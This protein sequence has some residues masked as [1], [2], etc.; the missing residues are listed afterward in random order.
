MP[1]PYVLA[2]NELTD[3]GGYFVRMRSAGRADLE[4]IADRIVAR[5]STVGKADVLAVLYLLIQVCIDLILEGWRVHLGGLVRLYCHVEGLFDAHDDAFDPRRHILKGT[6]QAGPRLNEA[7]QNRGQLR[8]Q[9]S[10]R[11]NPNPQ[12]FTDVVSGAHD[13]LTPGGMG[14]L[15]GSRL[16][17]DPTAEDEGLFLIDAAGEAH[18]L[19]VGHNT[20][21]LLI[22]S[23]P[24]LPPGVYYLET[25][26]CPTHTAIVRTA[27]LAQTLSVIQ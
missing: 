18:R 22:F 26:A 25:R 14:R 16:K 15:V 13:S 1:I 10:R 21:S 6:A 24:H 8:R 5:G 9:E 17:F 7:L 19:L 27:R 2:P 4:T 12:R 3:K 20:D 23:L 11:Q